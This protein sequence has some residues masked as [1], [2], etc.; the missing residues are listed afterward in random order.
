[1]LFDTR[2][3]KDYHAAR[4]KIDLPSPFSEENEKQSFSAGHVNL[5]WR[6]ALS[7]KGMRRQPITTNW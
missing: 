2:R 1:M 4:V 7:W 5:K 6:S 3:D